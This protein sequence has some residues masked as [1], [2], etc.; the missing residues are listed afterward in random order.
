MRSFFETKEYRALKKISSRMKIR[1]TLKNMAL[2]SKYMELC[3]DIAEKD[4]GNVGY[5]PET[6]GYVWIDALFDIVP[7]EEYSSQAAR[8]AITKY[9]DNYDAMAK[10]LKAEN[11]G[12]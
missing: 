7:E 2:Y 6:G 9:G 1:T 3:V 4:Y 10:E 8:E 12:Y 5:V 11:V